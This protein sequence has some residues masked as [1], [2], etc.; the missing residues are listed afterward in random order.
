ML[1]VSGDDIWAPLFR[2]THSSAFHLEVRDSYAVADEAEALRRWAA[3]EPYEREEQPDS[4]RA[5][6]ELMIETAGRDV[7]L[8]RLRV[9]TVPHSDYVRWLLENTADNV[10]TGEEVRWLPRNLVQPAEVPA[11]DYWL[12]DRTTVAYTTFAEDGAFMGLS[13]TTD[14]RLVGW[15]VEVRETLWPRGIDHAVYLD[16]ERVRM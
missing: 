4:W 14:P 2:A 9:I 7:A 3:G 16:S 1:H 15:A 8:E 12:F 5:W 6:D 11:D 13:I 10:E